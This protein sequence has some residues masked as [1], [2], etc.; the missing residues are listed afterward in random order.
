MNL[1][2]NKKNVT[3]WN[4]ILFIVRSVLKLSPND[5][6][7][8][9]IEMIVETKEKVEVRR[10][11]DLSSKEKQMLEEIK[12]ILEAFEFCTDELQG[13]RV[14]ISGVYPGVIFLKEKLKPFTQRI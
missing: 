13:N 2:L 11:G 12:N 8:I 6:K 7:T 1:K 5:F 14:N 3:R 10:K 9:R 4:S